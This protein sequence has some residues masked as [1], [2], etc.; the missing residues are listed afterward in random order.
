MKPISSILKIKAFKRHTTTVIKDGL[1]FF[2]MTIEQISKLYS[3][4]HA[5][6]SRNTETLSLR[7][8][9]IC[10]TQRRLLDS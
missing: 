7:Q 5:L 2:A 9:S 8:E 4:L 1:C 10:H 3:R 6:F